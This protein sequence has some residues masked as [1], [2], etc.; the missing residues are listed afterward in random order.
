M[1]LLRQKNGVDRIS[2]PALRSYGLRFLLSVELTL[3][4]CF[5]FADQVNRRDPGHPPGSQGCD[6]APGCRIL[7][8]LPALER[9]P[10]KITPAIPIA[11]CG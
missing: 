7:P 10:V 8:I 1:N 2:R 4:G 3:C 11:G 6:Q 9:P 5:G